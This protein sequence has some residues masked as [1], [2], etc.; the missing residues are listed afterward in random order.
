MGKSVEPR[1]AVFWF[2]ILVRR[3]GSRRGHSTQEWGRLTC[4]STQARLLLSQQRERG[5][6]V[7]RG[8]DPV[9]DLAFDHLCNDLVAL[10]A[11]RL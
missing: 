1:K 11:Q 3:C 9:G 5:T 4:A 10:V 8:D 6:G 2:P 7:A